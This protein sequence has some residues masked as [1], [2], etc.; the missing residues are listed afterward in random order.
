MPSPVL[1]TKLFVPPPRPNAVLRA[2]LI[3]RLNEGLHCKLTLIVAPAGFGKTSLAASWLRQLELRSE[4]EEWRKPDRSDHS[5]FSIPHSQF[6]AAWL[7]LDAAD[8][9]PA[10][11]LAHL[12]AALQTIAPTVGADIDALFQSPQPPPIDA[13]LP[14]LLNQLATLPQ[15]AI[16]VLDDYHLLESQPIDQA[17]AL[18]VEHLPPQL[19]LVLT[20]RED[21]PLPLARLRARGQLTEL[22][23]AGRR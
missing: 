12:V 8:A 17:L 9:D 22:R 23:A 18:V 15:S 4:N 6:K 10:R 16:L 14:L 20:T 1:A 11:F 7:S 13:L 2:D 5:S 3:A 19:H 21:P